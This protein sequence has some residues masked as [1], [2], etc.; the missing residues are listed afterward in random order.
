[1]ILETGYFVVALLDEKQT[2]LSRVHLVERKRPIIDI[3]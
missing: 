1:M 2:Q 3:Y